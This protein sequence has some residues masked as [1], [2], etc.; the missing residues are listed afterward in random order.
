MDR[1]KKFVQRIVPVVVLLIV[2]FR[3]LA[4][5]LDVILVSTTSNQWTKDFCCCYD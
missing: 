3:L 4:K 5:S 1:V 2:Q